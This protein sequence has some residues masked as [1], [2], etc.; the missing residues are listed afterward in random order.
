MLALEW[1]RPR[2]GLRSSVILRFSSEEPPAIT[3]AR[4]IQTRTIAFGITGSKKK[5]TFLNFHR[6]CISLISFLSTFGPRNRGTRHRRRPNRYFSFVCIPVRQDFNISIPS[7]RIIR[8]VASAPRMS[9]WHLLATMRATISCGCSLGSRP[10]GARRSDN[11]SRSR[12][13]HWQRC[14]MP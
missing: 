1:K 11:S 4:P 10:L 8:F 2:L 7:M 14:R 9:I 6:S 3:A 5:V 13:C 12:V